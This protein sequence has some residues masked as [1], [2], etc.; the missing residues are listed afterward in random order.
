MKSAQFN[1]SSTSLS[2]RSKL[3]VWGLLAAVLFSF[4]AHSL[5]DELDVAQTEHYQC[6]LCQGSVDLPKL[7]L[8]AA[9][10]VFIVSY[11]TKSYALPEL[12]VESSFRTPLLRAPPIS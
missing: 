1:L 3:L 12:I 6:Q 11:F 2:T 10:V 9:P 8:D 7:T 4:I 5:H